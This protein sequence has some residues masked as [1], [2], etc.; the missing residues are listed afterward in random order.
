MRFNDKIELGPS[1]HRWSTLRIHRVSLH[2]DLFNP[3]DQ[4]TESLDFLKLERTVT[5]DRY[6]KMFDYEHNF[7]LDTFKQE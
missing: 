3:F 6:E 7:E 1:T 5:Y 4:E 2:D